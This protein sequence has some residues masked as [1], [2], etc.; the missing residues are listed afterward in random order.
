MLLPEEDMGNYRNILL[1]K[2]NKDMGR[3][4]VPVSG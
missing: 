4:E 3:L 2:W 1:G